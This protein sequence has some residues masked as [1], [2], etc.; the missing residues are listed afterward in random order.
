MLVL[1]CLASA[2]EH[3]S[4]EVAREFERE[5]PCPSTGLPG[6]S[7]PDIG[8]TTSCRSHV[9]NP[10]PWRTCNGR[11]S[12]RRGLRTAG[13]GSL[14]TGRAVHAL[15]AGARRRHAEER[16]PSLSPSAT[17]A[18]E[19]SRRGLTRSRNGEE[20]DDPG[21]KSDRELF[22]KRH[23]GVLKPP[24]EPADIGAIDTSI[25]RKVFLRKTPSHPQPPQVPCHKR[26]RPHRRRRAA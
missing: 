13:S 6:G 8:E 14:A 18:W 21:V 5:H 19:W 25:D 2:N 26:L 9:A 24:L 1:P 3:R 10:T 16:T 11:R 15:L 20:L 23:G 12:P 22:E 7:C 17:A 4:H